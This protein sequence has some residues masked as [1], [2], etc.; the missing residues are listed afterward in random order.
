MPLKS[1]SYDNPILTLF[2]FDP[3]GG[4]Y[5]E[6]IQPFARPGLLNNR[7]NCGL[8]YMKMF[9]DQIKILLFHD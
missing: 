3:N 6:K 8:G 9:F 4:T 1:I 7:L 5:F 2:N